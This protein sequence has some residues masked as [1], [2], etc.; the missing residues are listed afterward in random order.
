MNDRFG[1]CIS[2]KSKDNIASFLENYLPLVN[3]SMNLLLY[4]FVKFIRFDET[5]VL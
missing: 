3:S 1:P 5:A 4:E 2:T